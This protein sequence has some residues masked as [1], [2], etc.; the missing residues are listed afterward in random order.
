MGPPRLDFYKMTLVIVNAYSVPGTVLRALP[1]I[2]QLNL[3]TSLWYKSYFY[4]HFIDE[5]TGAE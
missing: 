4:P 1:I 5:E 2:T 3:I